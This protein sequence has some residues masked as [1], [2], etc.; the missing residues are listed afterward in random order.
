MQVPSHQ[1][2]QIPQELVSEHGLAE[3]A[4][5]SLRAVILVRRCTRYVPATRYKYPAG[6]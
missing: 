3:L 5:G 1:A 2:L 6:R 4:Q